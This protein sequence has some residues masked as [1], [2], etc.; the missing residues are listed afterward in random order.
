VASEISYLC[1]YCGEHH[2]DLPMSYGTDAPAFWDPAL[3]DDESSTLEQE[4]CVIQAEHFFIRGRLVIP[5]IDDVA[6]SRTTTSAD[7]QRT[8]VPRRLDHR[9]EHLRSPVCDELRSATRRATNLVTSSTCA[10]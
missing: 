5:V 4:Q 8:P 1:R 9:Q 10:R 3:A 7:R 2:D 6:R